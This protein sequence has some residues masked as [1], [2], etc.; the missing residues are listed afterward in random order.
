MDVVLIVAEYRGYRS[1]II[2]ELIFIIEL[3][4]CVVFIELYLERLMVSKILLI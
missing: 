3:I 2:G 1:F 4:I